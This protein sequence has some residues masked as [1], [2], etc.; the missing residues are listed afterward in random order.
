MTFLTFSQ[1]W[2][3]LCFGPLCYGTL[4][5]TLVLYLL[6]LSATQYNSLTSSYTQSSFKLISGH[7]V[8]YV[9]LYSIVL[10]FAL[11]NAWLSCS[12][13]SWFG[14]LSVTGF[15]LK[16]AMLAW[17]VFAIAYYIDCSSSYFSS[18]DAYDSAITKLSINFWLSLIFLSNSIITTIFIIEVMSALLF[19]LITTSVYS[20]NFYYRNLDFSSYNYFQN[21]MPYTFINSIIYFFWTSLISSLNLFLFTI[22]LY[23]TLMSLD[24]YLIEHVFCYYI[25]VSSS[26]E[27]FSVGAVWFIMVFSILLKCGI[28]PFFI[29][30]PSFFKGLPLNTLFFYIVVFYFAIFIF[31][32]HFL[33]SYM[34]YF[35]NTYSYVMLSVLLVGILTLLSVL[36]ESFYIKSFLAVS[37]ILNSLLVFLALSSTHGSSVVMFL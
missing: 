10:F 16:L 34:F 20:T 29:W 22:Y 1:V 21:S 7:D 28:A 25:S 26:K 23:T 33:S 24:W 36:F 35:S 3:F 15:Q 14:H 32:I 17:F 37:S 13:S 5:T 9:V 31:F 4:V 27:L 6:P 18:R 19:L 30:K 11:W 12:F 8:Y 2:S